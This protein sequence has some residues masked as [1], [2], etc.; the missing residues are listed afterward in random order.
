MLDAVVDREYRATGPGCH[1]P[2][3]APLEAFENLTY[4]SGVITGPPGRNFIELVLLL[5]AQP[6]YW[7]GKRRAAADVRGRR[8]AP[9][10]MAQV[11]SPVT[12]AAA[13]FGSTRELQ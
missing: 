10:C 3:A 4:K 1:C 12:H 5:S 13:G 6:Q 11:T 2:M 8:G 7:R 9:D